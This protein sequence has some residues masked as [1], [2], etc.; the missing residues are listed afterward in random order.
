M[1][2]LGVYQA[3]CEVGNPVAQSRIYPGGFAKVIVKSLPDIRMEQRQFGMDVAGF[4][5]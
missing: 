2:R 4:K 3:T 1:V 5:V